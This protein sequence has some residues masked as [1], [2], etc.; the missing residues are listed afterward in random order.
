MGNE[1]AIFIAFYTLGFILV[2][3]SCQIV[4]FF[5]HFNLIVCCSIDWNVISL[6]FDACCGPVVQVDP[7]ERDPDLNWILPC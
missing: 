1:I 6:V 4:C 5:Y 7:F 3:L 2:L